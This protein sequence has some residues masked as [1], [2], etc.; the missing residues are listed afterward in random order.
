MKELHTT[1]PMI[2]GIIGMPG[3]GKSSFAREFSSMFGA[4]TLEIDGLR[5]NIFGTRVT[6]KSDEAG[7]LA[8]YWS[9]AAELIKSKRTFIMD[10]SLHT[11]TNR[12][13]V[14]TLAKKS[15]Y[16]IL[17]LWVQTS[18]SVARE[19]TLERKRGSTNIMLTTAE[20]TNAV[21]SFEPP[22]PNEEYIVTSGQRTFSSQVRP[23]LA[24]L[25]KVHESKLRPVRPI[26]RPDERPPRRNI[27]IR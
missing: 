24:K 26:D 14:R 12:S 10:G 15:G 4:P 18:E 22:H 11:Y 1:K 3:A 2:L 5:R 23:I 7:L 13:E 9:L 8:A 20:F 19:R 16:D 27:F 21:K 17:W 25:A 6:T